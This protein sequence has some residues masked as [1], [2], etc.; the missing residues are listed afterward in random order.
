MDIGITTVVYNGYG[1]FMDRFIK[2]IIA[3]DPQPTVVTI[4]LGKDHGVQEKYAW[5]NNVFIVWCEEEDNLGRLKNFAV[6]HTKAEWIMG[7]SVDDEI[8]PWAIKEFAKHEQGAD[9]IVSSYI[10]MSDKSICMHPKI[11]NEVL[12]SEQY[13]LK[14]GNYMHGSTPFRRALWE[15]RPYHEHDCFNTLFW[16]DCAGD[17]VSFAHTDIPC[18][19][20]NN[21]EGS[22]SHIDLD[23]RRKRFQ[24]INEYR[25]TKI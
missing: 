20:Y 8:L 13:Y 1:K 18:L 10:F 23:T 12:L 22:H 17:N 5:P 25:K 19:V 9:I 2:S 15:K 4:V 16:I 7:M 6:L 11:S 21:W 3:L 24:I 14:G